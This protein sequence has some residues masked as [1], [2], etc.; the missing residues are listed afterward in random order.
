MLE[1]FLQGPLTV[2]QPAI[3]GAMLVGIGI[4]TFVAVTPQGLGLPLAYSLLIPIVVQFDPY[5][6]IALLLGMDTKAWHA[7][8]HGVIKSRT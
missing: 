1:A 4:G 3:F 2:M 7:A 5:I 8:V 6:A